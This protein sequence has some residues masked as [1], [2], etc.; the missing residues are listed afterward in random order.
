MQKHLIINPQKKGGVFKSG[1]TLFYID[2]LINSFQK[3]KI[4]LKLKIFDID[5]RNATV[6]RF[7]RDN[8]QDN[9]NIK[10]N[11]I[12]IESKF[13]DP[14]FDNDILDELFNSFENDDTDVIIVDVGAGTTTNLLEWMVE[15]DIIE[16]LN[17]H[18]IQ[19]DVVIPV[20]NVKDSVAGLKDVFEILGTSPHYIILLNHY[21]GN[22]FEIFNNSKIKEN[23]IN[24]NNFEIIELPKFNNKLLTKLDKSN[25]LLSNIINQKFIKLNTLELQRFK[26]LSKTLHNI[27]QLYNINFNDT[28]VNKDSY[29]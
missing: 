11:N 18:N 23:I 5:N 14:K 22:D 28:N 26:K 2:Y 12:Q 20:T 24:A 16:L 17:E 4:P 10:D 19:L 1:M 8:I 6:E 9:T 7:L 29:E 27:F 3:S 13:I 25:L 21:L 15:T